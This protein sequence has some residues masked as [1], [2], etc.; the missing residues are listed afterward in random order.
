MSNGIDYTSSSS[1]AAVFVEKI[2]E[3][4]DAETLT[5]EPRQLEFVVNL[6]TAEKIGIMILPEILLEANEVIE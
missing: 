1:R 6:K 5:V 4:A 2:L 3:G